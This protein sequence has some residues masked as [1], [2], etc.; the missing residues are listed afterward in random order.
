MVHNVSEITARARLEQLIRAE[1]GI[2]KCTQCM[3]DVLCIALNK[4][5]PKYV[6]SDKGE[7][8]SRVDQMLIRQLS[9]DTDI[10]LIS[11]IGFVKKHPRHDPDS[12][13]NPENGAAVAVGTDAPVPMHGLTE[14][15]GN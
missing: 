9:M 2:C 15:N 12:A 5:P 3:D 10:A 6:S 11:S 8:F 1:T 14:E 7:L 13:T 4:L